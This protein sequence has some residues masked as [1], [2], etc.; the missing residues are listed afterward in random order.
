MGKQP[1]T[2]TSLNREI[3]RRRSD[4]LSDDDLELV[5]GGTA[6]TTSTATTTGSIIKKIGDTTDGLIQNQK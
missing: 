3:S 2:G 6:T 4:E 5:S 1:Q